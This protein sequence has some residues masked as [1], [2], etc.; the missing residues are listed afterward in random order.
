MFLPSAASD[1][2]QGKAIQKVNEQWGSIPS[3]SRRTGGWE[4][5]QSIGIPVCKKKYKPFEFRVE[6]RRKDG[7]VEITVERMFGC[8]A[9]SNIRKGVIMR[10]VERK[11]WV[12]NFCICSLISCFDFLFDAVFTKRS[13]TSCQKEPFGQWSLS[14]AKAAAKR[15]TARLNAELTSSQSEYCSSSGYESSLSSSSSSVEVQPVICDSVINNI[16]YRNDDSQRQQQPWQTLC[17]NGMCNWKIRGKYDDICSEIE[18]ERLNKE[19]V[20]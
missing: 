20:G 9:H 3:K 5:Y 17:H 6:R 15:E 12:S 8:H 11:G 14:K 16:L 4:G 1:T 2:L 18:E 19:D 13:T 10:H 7:S